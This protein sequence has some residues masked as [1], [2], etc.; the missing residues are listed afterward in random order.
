MVRQA[1]IYFATATSTA[2]LLT[3]SVAVFVVLAATSSLRNFPIPDLSGLPVPGLSGSNGDVAAAPSDPSSTRSRNIRHASHGGVSAARRPTDTR[4]APAGPA[5]PGPSVRATLHGSSISAAGPAALAPASLPSGGSS[6]IP[7]S[8]TSKRPSKQK[9][10]A[11]DDPVAT[12][13]TK[14][15]SVSDPRLSGKGG[16]DSKSAKGSKST[17]PTD[18]TI[19]PAPKSGGH[20]TGHDKDALSSTT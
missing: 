14:D 13:S 11:L 6:S 1:Q 2:L 18:G 7:A 10:S 3:A 19:D 17:V 20:G 16:A 12:P 8:G 4:S 9:S 5:R 15:P